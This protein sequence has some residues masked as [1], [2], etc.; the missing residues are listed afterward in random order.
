MPRRKKVAEEPNKSLDTFPAGRARG[1][2]ALIRPSEVMGRAGNYRLIFEQVWD[3]LWPLLS[4]AKTEEEVGKAFQ[5]G[6]NP[7]PKRSIFLLI[8]W[9]R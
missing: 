6:G 3:R 5:K 2:P 4:V 9:P 8:R 7:H 1:R